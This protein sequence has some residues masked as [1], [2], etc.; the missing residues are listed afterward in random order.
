MTIRKKYSKA[1]KFEDPRCEDTVQV[2][3]KLK[4]TDVSKLNQYIGKLTN[5]MS[6]QEVSGTTY[7][8]N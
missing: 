4:K 6:S 7:H 3:D 1:H 8:R 2:E 5:G